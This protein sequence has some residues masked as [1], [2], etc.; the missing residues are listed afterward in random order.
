MSNISSTTFRTDKN[1][2]FP[3]KDIREIYFHIIPRKP[4]PE[5]PDTLEVRI[6]VQKLHDDLVMFI[7]VPMT[8]NFNQ[9]TIIAGNILTHLFSL[10]YN[11]EILKLIEDPEYKYEVKYAPFTLYSLVPRLM[12]EFSFHRNTDNTIMTYKYRHSG[13]SDADIIMYNELY[14]LYCERFSYSVNKSLIDYY[15]KATD[16]ST[17]N[18][19][20]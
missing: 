15:I 17:D 9:S 10:F 18:N 16:I 20:Y 7:F 13:R 19:T 8:Y 6:D 12:N 2:Q 11:D 4:I 5:I 1:P 3:L 14:L